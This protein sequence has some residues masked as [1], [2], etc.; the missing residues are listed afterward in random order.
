MPL[1]RKQKKQKNKKEGRKARDFAKKV[2]D[3]ADFLEVGKEKKMMINV[4]VT[5]SV[6][7]SSIV[8]VSG[9]LPRVP[10]ECKDQRLEVIR[11]IQ[12][13]MDVSSSYESKFTRKKYHLEFASKGAETLY[14]YVLCIRTALTGKYT[15]AEDVLYTRSLIAKHAPSGLSDFECSGGCKGRSSIVYIS[16][17]LSSDEFETGVNLTDVIVTILPVCDKPECLIAAR[18]S[19]A[20]FTA[21]RATGASV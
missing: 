17:I 4:S 13:K 9:V 15:S 20:R 6:E 11:A 12:E 18:E 2:K 1:T 8:G 16:P 14:C 5:R 21:W 10:W 7:D 19:I 3:L